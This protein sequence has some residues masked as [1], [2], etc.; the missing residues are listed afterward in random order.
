MLLI[1]SLHPGE[2]EAGEIAVLKEHLTK[3]DFSFIAR[4]CSEIDTEHALLNRP[5]EFMIE[6]G[7]A[8]SLTK[9]EDEGDIR[10]TAGPGGETTR[11]VEVPKN[12]DRTHPHR[13]KDV[14]DA[15][16]KSDPV[17]IS[18]NR[19][20]IQ[21]VRRVHQIDKRPEL[22]YRSKFSGSQFSDA[23]V[24]WLA[25]QVTRDPA[26]FATARKRYAEML[27]AGKMTAKSS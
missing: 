7:Y 15:F 21:C 17:A 20:D 22:C 19:H 11:I 24:A 27:K 23:F 26:F 14:V 6:I 2:W 5:R 1:M 25:D 18:I 8:V 10:L 4:F 12:P 13:Q 16:N 3:D 9:R